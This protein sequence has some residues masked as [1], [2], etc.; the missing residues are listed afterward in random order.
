MSINRPEIVILGAGAAG[1]AAAT[2][3]IE[4]GFGNVTILEAEN[5]IGGRIHSVAFGGTIVD[6][7]AQWVHG[8]E[9]NIVYDLVKDLDLVSHNTTADYED[10]TFFTSDN[11]EVNKSLLIRFCDISHEILEDIPAISEHGGS[12]G[13]YF[14]EKF[15]KKI[16]AEFGSTQKILEIGKMVEGWISQFMLCYDPAESWNQISVNSLIAYKQCKGD[17]LINWRNKGYATLFDVLMKDIKNNSEHIVL[18]KHILLNK[19][20]NNIFW[21]Q[22][23]S[24]TNKIKIECSDGSTYNA[25]HV[26]VTFSV[27]AL[28][29]FHKTLFH[30]ELPPFK[31]N[32]LENIPLGNIHK[33]FLKFPKKW[34]PDDVKDF[35]FLW[36]QEEKRKLAEEFPYGPIQDKRSWLEDIFG[37]YSINSHPAMLLGWVVGSTIKQVELLPD[38]VVQN[39]SMFLLR[40]F[41]GKKY[42][43]LEPEAIL[44]SKWS[45]NPHFCGT[46]SY[47]STDMERRGATHE[48]LAEPLS[49]GNNDVVLFAGEATHSK[50]FSTVHGAIETGYREAQRLIQRYKNLEYHRTVIV[51]AGLAGLGAAIKLVENNINDFLILEAQQD[52]GGR[53]K[54]ISVD[55]KPLDLGAQWLHGKD[56][57]L[58]ELALKHGL[59]SDEMSE[60]G[61]GCYVRSNNE[62][63]DEFIVKKL[64]FQIGQILESCSKF[65]NSNNYPASLEEYLEEKFNDYLQCQDI[66]NVQVEYLKELYD[67]HV[68]FQIVDNS[69]ND[70]SRLSAKSWGEYI[71]HDDVAHYNLKSGYGPLVKVILDRLPNDGIRYTSE[72]VKIDFGENKKVFLY[73]KNGRIVVCDH[74]ILTPS[75]GVLKEFPGL[76][77]VL[78]DKLWKSI[79]NMGFAGICKI[80]LFYDDRWWTDSRGFQLLWT[81]DCTFSEKDSWLR[82]VTGFDEVFNHPNV[83]MTWVGGGEAVQQVETLHTDIIGEQ[84]TVLLRKFLPNYNVPVP[85][86]VIRT[87]WLSNPCVRGS[88]CHITPECDSTHL[89]IRKLKEPVLVDGVPRIIL[90]GEAIHPSHYSTTHGAYESG[91]DQ[92]AHLIDYLVAFEKN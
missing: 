46:W 53:I 19:E 92:A 49:V 21:D 16:S 31:I 91:Q 73:M 25:D 12:L 90:A 89:G 1:I 6:L 18:G 45:N 52:A 41:V 43:I 42:H 48:A 58:Y 47:V 77:N 85:N 32:C 81:R 36:S 67:W 83:L 10:V 59:I 9:D 13:D 62:I 88:Y 80:Y 20:V 26:I 40:K 54:T 65:L 74:L 14:R 69:C 63:L 4:N 44:R 50:Y 29:Q 79:V 24:Q 35:S 15:S 17:P 33:V 61:L 51:G 8:E 71:C 3:L 72:V 2:K 87:Q 68:R 75:L 64:D 76:S 27:A 34:W 70:L 22:R 56:N 82:Q 60:E 37:F 84:C 78:P 57:V 23:L 5:R 55:N 11:T 39:G 38:E 30:P 86:K 28:R 7:G 66:D